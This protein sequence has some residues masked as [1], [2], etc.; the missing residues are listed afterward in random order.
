[1]KKFFGW[2]LTIVGGGAIAVDLVYMLVM[3]ACSALDPTTFSFL[4]DAIAFELVP[5]VIGIVLLWDVK[6]KAKN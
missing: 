6:K 2:F 5:A 1:M 3:V 4:R